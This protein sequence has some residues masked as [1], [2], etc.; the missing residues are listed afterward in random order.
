MWK[1]NGIP[2]LMGVGCEQAPGGELLSQS[3]W[4]PAGVTP[5]VGRYHTQWRPFLCLCCRQRARAGAQTMISRDGATETI[6][7]PPSWV[8]GQSSGN[9]REQGQTRADKPRATDAVARQRDSKSRP[10]PFWWLS[11]W[12]SRFI[13]WR[14]RH[15]ACILLSSHSLQ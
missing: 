3:D 6:G 5:R 13:M 2:Q 8:G 9:P 7:L 4:L 11:P 15:C 12:R 14:R 1:C 10:L